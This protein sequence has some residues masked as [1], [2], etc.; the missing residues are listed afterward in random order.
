MNVLQFPFQRRSMG[1][2]PFRGGAKQKTRSGI[3]QTLERTS[4]MSCKTCSFSFH[5]QSK[6]CDQSI[7]LPRT[8]PPS[9]APDSTAS[10]AHTQS[11]VPASWPPPFPPQ[12][13]RSRA[14]RHVAYNRKV[15]APLPDHGLPP[16][17]RTPPAW[18]TPAA[19]GEY[20]WRVPVACSCTCPR[21]TATGRAAR[22]DDTLPRP[23]AVKRQTGLRLRTVHDVVGGIRHEQ[24]PPVRLVI[25]E[26]GT[27]HQD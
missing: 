27:V 12:P 25:H 16:A 15:S 26:N 22:A 24:V 2:E 9:H 5:H 20:R 18:D 10:C 21:A 14:N 6:I 1:S 17:S 23:L 13:C 3:S 7:S 4:N 11:S 8:T 19:V